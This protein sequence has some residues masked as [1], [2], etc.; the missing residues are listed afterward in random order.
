MNNLPK[1]FVI[2]GDL[3]ISII[4][5]RNHDQ[6]CFKLLKKLILIEGISENKIAD[7]DKITNVI[8]RNILIIEQKINYTFK[9]IIDYK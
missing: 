3:E 7:L 9:D 6:N 4:A 1:L 2:I 8:K 5:G